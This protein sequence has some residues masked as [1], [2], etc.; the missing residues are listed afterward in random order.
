[1]DDQK[2]TDSKELRQY[3]RTPVTVPITCYLGTTSFIQLTVDTK[4]LSEGGMR[5]VI[6]RELIAGSEI[7]VVFY[8][9]NSMTSSRLEE[10]RKRNMIPKDKNYAK[11][12]FELSAE[13]VWIHPS[14]DVPSWFDAGLK[15]LFLDDVQQRTL[16][17]FVQKH[18][19]GEL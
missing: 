9:P 6:P 7:T 18:Q 12:R 15:F 8:L 13:I 14:K 19:K 1:M 16:H 17:E 3:E 5:I 10:L 11:D 4:D 2:T